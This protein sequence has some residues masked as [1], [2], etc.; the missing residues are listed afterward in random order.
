MSELCIRGGRPNDIPQ[1]FELI[2]E[3]AIYENALHEVETTIE[4]LS[5]DA[6][7]ENPLFGLIVAEQE[8]SIVGI[9]IFYYRYSTWKG[10]RLY[11]EDILVTE[12]LRR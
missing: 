5:Q 8:K 9:S 10:K 7:G 4:Q 2:K 12:K 3:L 1:V 11:L 6:F